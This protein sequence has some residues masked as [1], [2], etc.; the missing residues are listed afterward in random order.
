LTGPQGSQGPQGDPAT[1][2]QQISVSSNGDTLFLQNGGFVIVPGVSI[3]SFGQSGITQSICGADS[4]HNKN[5]TYGVMNDQDGNSYKTVVVGIYNSPLGAKEWMAENLRASHFSNGD[6]VPLI[7]N[8]NNWESS[9]SAASCWY[10]NDS[11]GYNCPFGKLYNWPTVSDSRNI[12]PSGWHVPSDEEWTFLVSFYDPAANSTTFLES[13]TAGGKM[14]SKGT[15]YWSSPN[16]GANNISGFSGLPGGYR[17][18]DGSYN[19]Y[20]TTGYWWSSTP[21]GPT[22][23]F[24]RNINV[25]STVV[26]RAING[27][28]KRCGFAVRCVRN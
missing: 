22:A 24:T 3:A 16:I 8:N 13:Q 21:N 6:I 20:G 15:L 11:I 5:L 18:L 12:C 23:A 9:I 27:D 10:N 25:G 26:G 28:D 19:Y 14:K 17:Y 7:T 2:D 1:D 4:V